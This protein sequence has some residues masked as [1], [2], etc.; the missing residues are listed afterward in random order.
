[1]REELGL[2]IRELEATGDQ[3]LTGGRKKFFLK[4]SIYRC[5]AKFTDGNAAARVPVRAP[6]GHRHGWAK[7]QENVL[8]LG[9]WAGPEG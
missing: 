3:R 2:T 5:M 1:V 4:T 7:V 9:P 8:S 6:M